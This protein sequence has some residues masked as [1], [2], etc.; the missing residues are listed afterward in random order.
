[1][2]LHHPCPRSPSL[3]PN[4][5]GVDAAAILTARGNPNQGLTALSRNPRW[6]FLRGPGACNHP[7]P[8]QADRGGFQV[9]IFPQSSAIFSAI[10]FSLSTLRACWCPVCPLC[11]S[12]AP[13]SFRG[14]VTAPQ[15]SCNFP[16]IFPRSDLTL[17]DRNPP[18]PP[19]RGGTLHCR[20]LARTQMGRLVSPCTPLTRHQH[21]E[22]NA[23]N[24][25]ASP[26]VVLKGPQPL[27]L[28]G[29]ELGTRA[30]S[31]LDAADTPR[32]PAWNP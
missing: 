27:A 13:C 28:R 9:R 26:R 3:T 10:G 19:L 2:S 7:P 29:Q 12:V 6:V 18:L 11:R 31:P 25:C 30:V 5:C 20:P 16:A 15:F 8:W 14:L 1:M 24:C 22:R 23:F 4:S 21:Q 17:S 32:Q